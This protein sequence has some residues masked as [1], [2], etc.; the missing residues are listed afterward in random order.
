MKLPVRQ[1]IC[2]L[3]LLLAARSSFV[4]AQT[5]EAR[6]TSLKG[7]SAVRSNN[8]NVFKL[9]AGDA[10]KSGDVIDTRGGAQVLIEMTTDG[11]VVIVRPGSQVVLKDLRAAG[12]LRDLLEVLSGRVRVKINHFGGKPNPVRVNTPS[13]TIAVRGTEF[14]ITVEGNE[15]RVAVHTGLVEVINLSAPQQRALVEPGQGVIVRPNEAL[16]FFIPGPNSDIGERIG[17]RNNDNNN[18]SQNQTAQ[19]LN[20]GGEVLRKRRFPSGP[21]NGGRENSL[22]PRAGGNWECDVGLRRHRPHQQAAG[23]RP[24]SRQPAT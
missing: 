21:K 7:G 1:F 14:S 2:L 11:S 17:G 15:T 20:S 22:D 6:V 5:V 8:G 4:H 23:P 9:K 24:P 10:L 16:R 12:T 18:D 3:L 19:N 13:A